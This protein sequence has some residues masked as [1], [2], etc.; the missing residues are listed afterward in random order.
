MELYTLDRGFMKQETIDEFESAIWTERYYGEGDFELQ[1]PASDLMISKLA[2]GQLMMCQ[3]S[4]IP[5]ILEHREIKAGI[6]KTTGIDLVK[7]LNNRI[8]RTSNDHSVKEKIVDTLKAGELLTWL[9]QNFVISGVYLDG[10]TPIA[11]TSTDRNR[12][13]IP[14]LVIGATDTSGAIIEWTVPFGPL[15]DALSPIATTYEIGMKIKLDSSS[16]SGYQISFHNYKGA[17]RT[18]AQGVNP[19]IQFSPEMDSFTNITDLDSLTDYRN[20]ILSFA[21]N[22]PAAYM[23][24]NAGRSATVPDATDG[25]DLRVYQDFA[26]FDTSGL[27]VGKIGT[28]LNEQ[29]KKIGK[30]LT[31]VQLVDGEI[32]PN[33]QIKYGQHYFLGDLVEVKGNSGVKQNARITEYIRSQDSAGSR[34]Y[35]TLTMIDP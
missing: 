9:V 4:D 30:D 34:A 5:M 11:I 17:D 24:G 15:F 1:V 12:F 13:D 14:G 29:A 27:T 18:S 25:F 19:V 28:V 10:T 26:D 16:A 32:V 31:V 22:A 6:L 2:K 33:E 20:L 7:W 23:T 21:A 35:P 8:V 3:G